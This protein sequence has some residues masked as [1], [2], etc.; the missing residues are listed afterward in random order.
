MLIALATLIS[1]LFFGGAGEIFYVDK[2]EK[3]IKKY[4]LEKDRKKEILAEVKSAKSVFKDFNKARKNDFKTFSKMYIDRNTSSAQLSSFIDE[5]QSS[6]N[7]FQN[8]IIDQRLLIFAKIK[9]EEWNQIVETSQTVAE[10]RIEKYKKKESKA[11][12]V[13]A[14]T[15]AKIESDILNAGKKSNLIRGLEDLEKSIKNLEALIVSIN[16]VHNEILA[17]KDAGKEK[18]I[19]FTSEENEQRRILLESLIAFRN[20]AKD[21]LAEIEWNKIMKTFSKE[22]Q[23]SSR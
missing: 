14:K 15:K 12:D 2:F 3:G 18:L 22:M 10:K 7:E 1:F 5:L 11:K 6:R 20:T 19:E 8:T 16:P 23:I 17:D 9:P 13:F 4:V 21:N